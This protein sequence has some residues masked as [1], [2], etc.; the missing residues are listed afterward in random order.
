M[1]T[2]HE[3]CERYCAMLERIWHAEYAAVLS[4]DVDGAILALPMFLFALDHG[5]SGRKSTSQSRTSSD[6]VL[7]PAR[8]QYDIDA[9]VIFVPRGETLRIPWRATAPGINESGVLSVSCSTSISS[10]GHVYRPETAACAITV[11]A[12]SE[13]ARIRAELVESGTQA[14]WEAVDWATPIITSAVMRAHAQLKNS[15]AEETQT[16]PHDWIDAVTFDQLVDVMRFGDSA[17]PGSLHRLLHLACHP[18]AFEK[19]DPIK[20]AVAHLRRDAVQEV[21]AV[22]GDSRSGSKIR[23]LARELGTTDIEVIVNEYRDRYPDSRH[24]GR[25]T[26]HQA[27]NLS[28][29]VMA[30]SVPLNAEMNAGSFLGGRRGY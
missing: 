22:I 14:T 5:A 7:M 20:H 6:P 29:D 21:R 19:V 10:F 23:R 25:K 28:P 27:L 16:E 24:P 1:S 26:V 3:A 15:I 8:I 9:S 12:T 18:S 17:R 2:R 30:T 4:D 11:P 13:V